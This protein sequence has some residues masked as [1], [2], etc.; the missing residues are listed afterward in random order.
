MGVNRVVVAERR[1]GDDF[2]LAGRFDRPARWAEAAADDRWLVALGPLLQCAG[3]G[4]NSRNAHYCNEE[5]C[6]TLAVP[7]YRTRSHTQAQ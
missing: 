4:V 5:G 2:G 7:R 1:V 6:I 3:A